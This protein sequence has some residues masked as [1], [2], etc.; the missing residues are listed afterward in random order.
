MMNH[1]SIQNVDSPPLDPY[2]AQ[3][4]YTIKD[5]GPRQKSHRLRR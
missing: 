5:P 3:Y 2:S 4:A 1:E